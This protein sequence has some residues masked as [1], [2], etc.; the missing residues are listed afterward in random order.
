MAVVPVIFAAIEL[1]LFAYVILF[2]RERDIAR[3]I[4]EF[5]AFFGW[6]P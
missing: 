2:S 1:S 5:A 3:A 4:E 6:K